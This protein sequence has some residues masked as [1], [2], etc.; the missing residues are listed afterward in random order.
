M[1][2]MMKK[3]KEFFYVTVLFFC[4]LLHAYPAASLDVHDVRR[5]I[6]DLGIEITKVQSKQMLGDTQAGGSIKKHEVQIDARTSSG[7]YMVLVFSGD[8]TIPMGSSFLEK[9]LMK[10]YLKVYIEKYNTTKLEFKKIR[11]HQ[12]AGRHI[13]LV[14]KQGRTHLNYVT[15]VIDNKMYVL[16]FFIFNDYDRIFTHRVIEWFKTARKIS[17]AELIALASEKESSDTNTSVSGKSWEQR[18]CEA[19]VHGAKSDLADFMQQ[20]SK[21][22]LT[23][24]LDS[25]QDCSIF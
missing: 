16:K 23:K 2:R 8:G 10:R 9:N 17:R 6:Y 25:N 15:A 20:L 5:N 21:E 22:N 13:A 4:A 1:S 12:G 7:A 24:F 14:D 19:A 3:T 11:V 18:K